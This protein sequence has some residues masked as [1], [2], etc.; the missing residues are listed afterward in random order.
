VSVDNIR[1]HIMETVNV[2]GDGL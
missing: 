1:I 2:G